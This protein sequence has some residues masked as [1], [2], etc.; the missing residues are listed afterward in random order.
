MIGVWQIKLLMVSN[1][2]LLVDDNKYSHE[3]P[4]VVTEI[5]DAIKEHFGELVISRGNKHDFL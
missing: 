5:L 4:K 3:D 2:L 1:V